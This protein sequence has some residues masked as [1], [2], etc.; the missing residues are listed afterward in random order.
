MKSQDP[1][2]YCTPGYD[3]F[4]SCLV[5]RMD[6]WETSYGLRAGL[7]NAAS[8][9][10][11]AFAVFL[12]EFRLDAFVDEEFQ[13]RLIRDVAF[14]CQGLELIEQGFWQTE[15]DGLGRRFQARENHWP[16]FGVV[17]ILR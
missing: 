1:P 17:D 13:K 9:L 16:A 6:Q 10:Y 15:R 8:G 7:Q 12:M 11:E 2:G 14:V 5:P 3:S 4:L